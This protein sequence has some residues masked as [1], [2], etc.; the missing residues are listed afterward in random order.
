MAGTSRPQGQKTPVGCC[1]AFVLA[2][3][4]R[5]RRMPI[6]IYCDQ[7]AMH[8]D[9]RRVQLLTSD[10][11]SLANDLRGPFNKKDDALRI[12]KNLIWSIV[13]NVMDR[14]RTEE[15]KKFAAFSSGA[16]TTKN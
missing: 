10:E 12:A 14:L 5:E 13:A 3:S 11:L 4:F 9:L 8:G 16:Q 6:W 15:P 1:A 2:F 7:Q